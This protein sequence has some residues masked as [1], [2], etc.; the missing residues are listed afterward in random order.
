MLYGQFN[1]SDAQP[2]TPAAVAL[3]TVNLVDDVDR[4]LNAT[5]AAMVQATA[6]DRGARLNIEQRD[7]ADPHGHGAVISMVRERF[8]VADLLRRCRDLNRWNGGVYGPA[9]RD[10]FP[11]LRGGDDDLADDRAI[12]AALSP[13]VGTV[14]ANAWTTYSPDQMRVNPSTCWATYEQRL[15]IYRQRLLLLWNNP[16]TW[17][18]SNRNARGVLLPG[19]WAENTRNLLGKFQNKG[20]GVTLCLGWG[21]AGGKQPRVTEDDSFISLFKGV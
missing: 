10:D 6:A 3:P 13:L 18:A 11:G 15:V 1:F 7:N 19:W 14:E 8:A 2:L 5:A 21:G 12:A 4:D 9:L 20:D 17:W 16:I